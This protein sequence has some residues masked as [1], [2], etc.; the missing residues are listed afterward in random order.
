MA[1][2]G[3]NQICHNCYADAWGEVVHNPFYFVI[4]D[5]IIK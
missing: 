5:I 4:H 2:E 3:Q 1:D